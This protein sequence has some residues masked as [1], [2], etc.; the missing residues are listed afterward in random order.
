MQLQRNQDL[1]VKY[2]TT[3]PADLFLDMHC[4]KKSVSTVTQLFIHSTTINS[5]PLFHS[6]IISTVPLV[7]THH[8]KDALQLEVQSTAFPLY[9]LNRQ[10]TT[11]QHSCQNVKILQYK[12]FPWLL[13]ITSIY[14]LAVGV[15]KYVFLIKCQLIYFVQSL[16]H[17][18]G[19][20]VKYFIRH[21]TELRKLH[22]AAM[23]H[24][25][26]WLIENCQ[27]VDYWLKTEN[28]TLKSL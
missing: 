7:H 26:S 18:N 23:L 3:N 6:I 15:Q 25:F 4:Y 21:E 10:F 12:G 16:E 19:Q 17:V 20:C 8:H 24:H 11:P 2:S 28:P 22:I 5:F 9:A 13:C 27:L 14:R 1:T